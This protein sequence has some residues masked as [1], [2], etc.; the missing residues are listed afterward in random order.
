M[1]SAT[2]P[3]IV[4]HFG[5]HVLEHLLRWRWGEAS[6]ETKEGIKNWI[7]MYIESGTMEFATEQ[8]MIKEKVASLL[9]NLAVRE[10]PQRWTG[11]VETLDTIARRGHTQAE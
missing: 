5:L 10:W 2:H 6:P 11:L 3:L 4:R 8:A 1:A 9:A 7:L